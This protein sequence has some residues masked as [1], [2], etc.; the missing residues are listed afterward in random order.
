MSNEIVTEVAQ[1]R[2]YTPR[3][4]SG[5]RGGYRRRKL[6][7]GES[8]IVEAIRRSNYASTYQLAKE[9][10]AFWVF[11]TVRNLIRMGLVERD[12]TGL[13]VTEKLS[14][15]GS[16]APFWIPENATQPV[17][18][19]GAAAAAVPAL[20]R[21]PQVITFAQVRTA[22]EVENPPKREVAP[23]ISTAQLRAAREAEALSDRLR[24]QRI[25]TGSDVR[26][27]VDLTREQ[28]RSRRKR[29]VRAR[30]ISIKSITKR[31]LE[32]GRLLYPEEITGRPKTRGECSGGKRPCPFVSC[33]YNLFLDV[34]PDTGAIKLNFPDIEPDEM[35]ESCMLDVADRGGETL[36]TVGAHLNLTRERLRQI[37]EGALVQ[38]RSFPIDDF[39]DA[40]ETRT[41]VRAH[42]SRVA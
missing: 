18:P 3:A 4:P 20:T 27:Q 11:K 37:E 34:S 38:L 29:E 16:G 36:E 21:Y 40:S 25:E 8:R 32:L 5:P 12:A 26:Q 19:I 42:Q 7:V 9:L 13:R 30:T 15:V 2:R 10:N 31:D 41:P 24:E 33:R 22:Y 39:D 1:K 28:D 23:Q 14:L 6:R 17:A 35:G